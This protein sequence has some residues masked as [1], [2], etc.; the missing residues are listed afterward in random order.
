MNK[1]YFDVINGTSCPMTFDE[2]CAE[3][4]DNPRRLGEEGD[5]IYYISFEEG[6]DYTKSSNIIDRLSI[7]DIEACI[8]KGGI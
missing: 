1:I 4:C 2:V 8:E 7:S 6:S 3:V 5:E